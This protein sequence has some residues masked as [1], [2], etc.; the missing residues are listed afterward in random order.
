MADQEVTQE[1]LATTKKPMRFLDTVVFFGGGIGALLL[2][3]HS[4]RDGLQSYLKSAWNEASSR[5][6]VGA[7]FLIPLA[8][9]VRHALSFYRHSGSS[10][11]WISLDPRTGKL[12]P[13]DGK[14]AAIIEKAFQLNCAQ[15]DLAPSVP[16]EIIFDANGLHVQKTRKGT[17]DVRRFAQAGGE[18]KLHVIQ[19][20]YVWKV[21]NSS[22]GAIE[23]CV[24]VPHSMVVSI[25]AD[26]SAIARQLTAWARRVVS[27]YALGCERYRNLKP[28]WEWCRVVGVGV[29]AMNCHELPLSDWGFYEVEVNQQIERAFQAGETIREIEVGARSF[30]VVFTETGFANQSDPENHTRRLVRRRLVPYLS[31]PEANADRQHDVCA[32]CTLLLGETATMPIWEL[33]C[34]HI[35]HQ[36]CALPI[37]NRG[38]PCPL[39]RA[40][41]DWQAIR[42]AQ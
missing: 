1:L 32:I 12:V 20:R 19:P 14:V 16:G 9:F 24:D 42:V 17:R 28:Q 23:E 3:S 27:W 7:F 18:V 37:A 30:H 26:E 38:D 4:S 33:P 22:E 10:A 29:H 15:A 40:S 34:G 11:V 6:V 5:T 39:C 21:A 13:Y 8:L 2:G 25:A 41:V 36:V 35:F 31:V